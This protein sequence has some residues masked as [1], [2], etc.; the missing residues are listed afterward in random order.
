MRQDAPQAEKLL[1]APL[2][3]GIRPSLIPMLEPP[4]VRR[5]LCHPIG[6]K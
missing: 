3:Q 4:D 6:R 2:S 5:G 1:F